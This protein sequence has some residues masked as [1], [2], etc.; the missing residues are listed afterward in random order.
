MSSEDLRVL[1]VA[2]LLIPHGFLKKIVD[3]SRAFIYYLLLRKAI[4]DRV[5]EVRCEVPCREGG[6]RYGTWVSGMS[7]MPNRGIGALVGLWKGRCG[8]SL[9]GVGMYEP[10]VWIQ[11]KN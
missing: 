4:F 6:K 8:H 3:F 2:A 1:T 10:G 7:K 9:Q 11:L 5:D